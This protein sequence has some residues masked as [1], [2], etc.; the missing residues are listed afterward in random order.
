L[1]WSVAAVQPVFVLAMAQLDRITEDTLGTTV[2]R[3]TS[4]PARACFTLN[5]ARRTIPH[6]MN[7]PHLS[8]R[9]ASATARLLPILLCGEES[10]ALVFDALQDRDETVLVRS[11]LRDI[12]DDEYRHDGWLRALRADLPFEEIEPVLYR[13]MRR[14]YLTL[15]DRNVAAHLLRIVALDSAVCTILGALRA[16]TKPLGVDRSVSGLLG[17]ILRDEARHLRA[18]AH[19]FRLMPHANLGAKAVDVAMVAREGLIDLLRFRAD[20]F[21]TLQV[22][23][24]KLFIRLRRVPRALF[25]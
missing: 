13:A 15:G 4:G 14:Y 21:D 2:K 23:P 18:A 8:D 9:H 5:P 7:K 25:A 10:A 24:D 16:R 3:A 20:A 12:A 11:A 1:S 22:D 19:L 6:R 17:M